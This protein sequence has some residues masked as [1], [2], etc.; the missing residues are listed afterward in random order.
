M[1]CM[2]SVGGDDF[3]VLLGISPLASFDEVKEAYR[4][5]ALLCHPDKNRSDNATE[6]FQHLGEAWETLRDP[7]RRREYDL[8]ILSYWRNNVEYEV[9]R[10]WQSTRHEDSAE[11]L[12]R[13]ARGKKFR[14]GIQ[15]AYFDRSQ[16]WEQ[17]L[18]R[19]WTAINHYHVLV[20]RYEKQMEE[21]MKDSHETM[22]QKFNAAISLS[23]AK[24]TQFTDH[25]AVITKLMD[26]RKIYLLNLKLAGQATKGRLQYLLEELAAANK[27]FEQEEY[28]H[29][30]SYAREALE[31]LEIERSLAP[32][33]TIIDRRQQSI[34]HWKALCR[35]KVHSSSS[36]V[37][38]SGGTWHEEASWPRV[39]GEHIC[40]R[41]KSAAFHLIPGMG[42]ASCP[43]CSLIVCAN[44]HHDLKI[45]RDFDK[46]MRVQE[47][48]HGSLFS[49]EFEG[50][51][52]PVSR[53][54]TGD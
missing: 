24:G 11:S 20:E 34:N 10:Q 35:V 8:R 4:K 26:A 32:L 18:Q 25:E 37:Q 16:N 51:S 31:V 9:R 23:E 15:R 47:D 44:C 3:Y 14:E 43:A 39:A 33:F 40:A 38:C 42:A 49:L 28:E 45:L 2:A 54:D 36:T 19:Q 50:G 17:F 29:R 6:Q 1:T 22:L 21:Q 30:Q 53:S 41:C 46:W 48:H 13:I 12:A 52:E 27:A 7:H 5:Q